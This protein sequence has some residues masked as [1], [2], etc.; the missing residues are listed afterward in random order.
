LAAAL[1]LLGPG[2][3]R[4]SLIAVHIAVHDRTTSVATHDR[5]PSLRA[6]LKR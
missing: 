3:G 1:D 4:L 2:V 5:P 6:E